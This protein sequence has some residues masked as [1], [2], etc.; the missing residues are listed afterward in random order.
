MSKKTKSETLNRKL[1]VAEAIKLV[2]PE[3]DLK[4]QARIKADQEKFE[5]EKD[6]LEKE[7]SEYRFIRTATLSFSNTLDCLVNIRPEAIRLDLAEDITLKTHSDIKERVQPL[8]N[9][10]KALLDRYP[11][12]VLRT[13]WRQLN[14]RKL[15]IS[16]SMLK[17][18]YKSKELTTTEPEEILN[19]L[20]DTV[21]VY[22]CKNYR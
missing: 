6:A 16:P 2:K 4:V 13:Y 5:K 19:A 1:N 10:Y 3:M 8:I 20:F 15:S 18:F 14:L 11:Y 7:L 21:L 9:R 17:I 22:L 12:P